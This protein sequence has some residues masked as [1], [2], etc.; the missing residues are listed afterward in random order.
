MNNTLPEKPLLVYPSLA[1]TI[2]LEPATLL[3]LLQ[4]MTQH[5]AAQ[6]H[7]QYDWYTL[8]AA[9]IGEATPFWDALDIQRLS[10]QLRNLGLILLRSAPYTQSH[11]LDFAFN[12]QQP[13]IPAAKPATSQRQLN[14]HATLIAANWQPDQEV[15]AGLAQ[16][17]IPEHF[18]REQT[19]EFVRYW[20]ESGEVQRSWGS[21]FIQYTKRQWAFH[22]RQVARQNKASTLPPNWQPSSEVQAQI[23]DEGIP[24]TFAKKVQTKFCL[25]HQ[26]SGMTQVNWDIPFLS[27]VKEA[28]Q[29]QDT[30][31][32][33]TRSRAMYPQWQPDDH[34]RDYLS[35]SHGIEASFIDNCIPEFVHKWIEKKAVYAEWGKLFAEHVIEQW[36]FVKNGIQRN[37]ERK[38]IHKHWRPSED[39]LDILKVQAEI[40]AQFIEQQIPEFILYWSNR[41]DPMHSW[42]NIFLKHIKHLWTG[43]HQGNTHERQHPDPESTRTK[44]RSISQQLSDRSWAS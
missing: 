30:P 35:S 16:L 44:D 11:T 41:G 8:S 24:A 39:C 1:A 2:G 29:K 22:N 20:R 19:P 9:V 43:R 12:Q 3:S 34:T 26:Q 42:D 6:R 5:R 28:W 13:E 18:A 4:D 25:Y 31:F 38:P 14:H 15:I 32:I 17:N 40:D 27:W 37:P 7:Q 36:R 10:Q 23:G 21:K 33:E